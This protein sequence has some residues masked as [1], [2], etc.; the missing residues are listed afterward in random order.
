MTPGG[1]EVVPGA[2]WKKSTGRKKGRV[3]SFR[4]LEFEPSEDPKTNKKLKSSRVGIF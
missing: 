3:G 1:G 2:I 4:W